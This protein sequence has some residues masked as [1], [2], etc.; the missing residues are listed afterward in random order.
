MATKI[1]GSPDLN[2]FKLD[3]FAVP[4]KAVCTCNGLLNLATS[5]EASAAIWIASSRVG[6]RMR[7]ETLPRDG[8]CVRV[9]W[10]AGSRKAVVLPVPVLA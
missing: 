5:R 3:A 6:E 2:L 10:I 8:D 4:P 7:I 1:F 9:F